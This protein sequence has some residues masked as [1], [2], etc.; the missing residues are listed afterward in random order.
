MGPKAA[1]A[2]TIA[3]EE[4]LYEHYD[5]QVKHLEVIGVMKKNLQKHW[6]GSEMRRVEHREVTL[7]MTAETRLPI[8]ITALNVAGM[9][10]VPLSRLQN[11]SRG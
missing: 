9:A 1:M 8:R 10:V 5:K 6:H 4:V 3:V 7:T 2:C 11:G